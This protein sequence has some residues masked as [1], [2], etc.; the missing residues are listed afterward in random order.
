[1]RIMGDQ[2]GP[3]AVRIA[4][5]QPDFPEYSLQGISFGNRRAQRMMR[6]D[7]GDFE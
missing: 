2:Y 7:A 6:I 3:F 5:L 1:M 4:Q